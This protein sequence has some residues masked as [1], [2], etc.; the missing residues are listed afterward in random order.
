MKHNVAFG[1]KGQE[2]KLSEVSLGISPRDN[3]LTNHVGLEAN[4]YYQYKS[5]WHPYCCL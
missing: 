4:T 1:I 3:P 2:V 5:F